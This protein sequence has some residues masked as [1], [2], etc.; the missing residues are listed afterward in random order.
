VDGSPF[1][2][3]INNDDKKTSRVFNKNFVDEFVAMNPLETGLI[4]TIA[5]LDAGKKETNTDDIETNLMD[6]IHR[7]IQHLKADNSA[8]SKIPGVVTQLIEAEVSNQMEQSK[9][10]SLHIK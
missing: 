10:Y 1:A 5:D 9:K 4:K 2:Y 3:V 7:F 8:V 6:L